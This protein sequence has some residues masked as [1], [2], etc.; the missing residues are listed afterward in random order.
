MKCFKR[1]HYR[2]TGGGDVW[3][4][5]AGGVGRGRKVIAWSLEK[6]SS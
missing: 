5:G 6:M 1:E 2:I 4:F 3:V